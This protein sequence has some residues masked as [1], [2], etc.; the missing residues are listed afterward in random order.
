[1]NTKAIA[2][3]NGLITDET[4]KAELDIIDYLKTL[5][6]ADKEPKKPKWEFDYD[7]YFEKTWKIYPRKTDKVK[8]KQTYEKKIYGLVGD[9]LKA[10]LNAIYLKTVKYARYVEENVEDLKFCKLYTTFLNAE[11]E[12]TKR[13]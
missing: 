2:F 5:V 10:K 7:D 11:F 6:K 8:A 4:T 13:K 12:N 3:L 9:E 1:M